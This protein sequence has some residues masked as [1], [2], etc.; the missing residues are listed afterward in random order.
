MQ[1][2]CFFVA[3][4]TSGRCLEVYLPA[5]TNGMRWKFDSGIL[6][7]KILSENY[8]DSIIISH[9]F[10]RLPGI[11]ICGSR[12]TR[13]LARSGK[14]HLPSSYL[15][16]NFNAII[17]CQHILKWYVGLCGYIW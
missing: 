17:F 2:Q 9:K 1:L 5:W 16:L 7:S 6:I 10:V 4:N 14:Y 11:I 13:L 8:L 3:G 15:N 12:P